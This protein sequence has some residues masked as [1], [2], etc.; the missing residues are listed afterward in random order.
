MF[1]LAFETCYSFAHI[2]YIYQCS[3][4][5]A[6]ELLLHFFAGM[7]AVSLESTTKSVLS[8]VCV[9]SVEEFGSKNKVQLCKPVCYKQAVEPG[10]LGGA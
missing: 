3:V 6:N 10:D 5:L 4:G 2:F 7:L 8:C 9:A 1:A